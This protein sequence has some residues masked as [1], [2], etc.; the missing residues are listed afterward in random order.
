[1]TRPRQRTIS[2]RTSTNWRE[3]HKNGNVK[4]VGNNV[5]NDVGNNV[6]NSV[7]N[8]VGD[9]VGNDVGIEV[10]N[11]VGYIK[12]RRTWPEEGR[13]IPMLARLSR[14][15]GREISLDK[16]MRMVKGRISTSIF[17]GI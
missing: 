10:G 16:G 15:G 4:E 6:V 13:R 3:F 7:G 5:G 2:R 11:D 9:D 1:M 8:D 14:A 12:R 17:F